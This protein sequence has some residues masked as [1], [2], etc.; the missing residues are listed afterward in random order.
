[1]E[2]QMLIISQETVTWFR[3]KLIFRGIFGIDISSCWYERAKCSVI[4]TF[5]LLNNLCLCENGL[6]GWVR[7]MIIFVGDG[8]HVWIWNPIWTFGIYETRFLFEMLIFWYFRVKY[9]FFMYF[10]ILFQCLHEQYIKIISISVWIQLVA[11]E[12]NVFISKFTKINF[13][14]LH[15]H[16]RADDM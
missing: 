2:Q 16:L 6:N 13:T 4:L 9:G 1:M 5:T 7:S 8:L 14:T 10:S 3:L 11:V 12:L 15:W